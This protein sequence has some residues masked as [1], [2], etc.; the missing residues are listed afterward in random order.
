MTTTT[1]AQPIDAELIAK[2]VASWQTEI[3]LLQDLIAHATGSTGAAQPLDLDKLEA[4]AKSVPEHIQL[5]G[6]FVEKPHFGHQH[7][8]ADDFK[9]YGRQHIATLPAHKKYFGSMAEFIAKFNPAT[10]R[11]LID[12]A[13]RAQPR[14][15]E[16]ASELPP[17]P[18][19]WGTMYS[20]SLQEL[21]GFTADQMRGYA[22]DY[23]MQLGRAAL[24]RQA[25]PEQ[26]TYWQ[27]RAEEAERAWGELYRQAAPEAPTE[28]TM[29]MLA[30]MVGN[31]RDR[32]VSIT[33]VDAKAIYKAARAATPAAQQAAP[34]APTLNADECARLLSWLAEYKQRHFL[35]DDDDALIAKLKVAPAPATPR[36]AVAGIEYT[37][38]NPYL[39]SGV[40]AENWD[41]GYKGLRF[42][43]H[44]GSPAHMFFKEG[45]AARKVAPATQ[46]AGAPADFATGM[47]LTKP[48]ATNA[49]V[50][51]AWTAATTASAS[52]ADDLKFRDLLKFYVASCADG[53][54][55]DVQEKAEAALIAHLDG[56]APAPGQEAA[57]L[58]WMACERIADMPAVD[59][60]LRN[61]TKDATGDNATGIIAA[62]A[63]T[64]A[65]Q[66]EVQA[67]SVHQMT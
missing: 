33:E 14:V 2:Q 23:A 46:Q 22:I 15:T 48:D 17:L 64:L 63:A 20:D 39:G 3:M 44:I 65:Q 25:A 32:G 47:R 16:Q 9:G 13:R 67:E 34:V 26:V 4:L 54:R 6:W 35:M 7:V 58:D 61:F 56:R 12:L 36:A 60:A 5:K 1:A 38:S 59:E 49:E 42:I 57:P 30:A 18:A 62:V 50:N 55:W 43:G 37:E 66:G 21:D 31:A 41:R 19:A 51:A 27:D 29:A 28:P 10:V 11:A 24:T 8:Y 52:I 40:P 45:E 53:V